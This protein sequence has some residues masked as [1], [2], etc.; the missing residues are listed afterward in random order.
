M[1]KLLIKDIKLPI[2]SSEDD[3]FA[4]VGKRIGKTGG[5]KLS[6]YKKSL[7]MRRRDNPMY[8]YSVLAEFENGKLVTLELMPLWLNFSLTSLAISTLI[9]K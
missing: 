2:T 7:D 3:V 4:N 1:K 9:N 8:V 5:Y 6:V